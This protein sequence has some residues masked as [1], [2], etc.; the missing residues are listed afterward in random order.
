MVGMHFV[1]NN[2]LAGI[3]VSWNESESFDD[4][5]GDNYQPSTIEIHSKYHYIVSVFKYYRCIYFVHLD[6]IAHLLNTAT[7]STWFEPGNKTYPVAL[8]SFHPPPP[9]I[10]LSESLANASKPQLT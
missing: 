4:D 9:D 2:T 5:G 8:S 6:S 1:C 7:V 3:V 10:S